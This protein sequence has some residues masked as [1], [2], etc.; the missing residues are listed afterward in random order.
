MERNPEFAQLI[1][2][3]QQLRESLQMAANPV[4]ARLHLQLQ[5]VIGVGRERVCGVCGCVCVCV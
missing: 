3:P 4:S 1:N 2:N 5:V